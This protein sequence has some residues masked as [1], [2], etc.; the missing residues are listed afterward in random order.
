M[1]SILYICMLCPL[2][3]YGHGGQKHSEKEIPRKIE[4]DPL[5]SIY[6]SINADYNVKVAGILQ[7][8]C[9]DCHSTTT[10]YPWYYKIPGI[11]LI[12][13]QHILEAR[14]HLDMTKGFPFLS[15]DKP[16]EDLKAIRKVILN[17]TMPPWYYRPFHSSSTI[18]EEEKLSI[19][20]WI[21]KSLQ[22][23]EEKK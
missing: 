21:N 13:N 6:K 23:I 20:N 18:T 22:Q 8:K 4:G 3:V 11:N 19:I 1:K 2:L 17:G 10:K 9:F 15:H 5:N 14:G 16:S 7:A 12:I